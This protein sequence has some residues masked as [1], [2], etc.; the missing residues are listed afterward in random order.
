MDENQVVG[1]NLSTINLADLPPEP[2]EPLPDLKPKYKKNNPMVP[3]LLI[4]TAALGILAFFT[5]S[6]QPSIK[7]SKASAD[8]FTI[9]FNTGSQ[10]VNPGDIVDVNVLGIIT[11]PMSIS[12]ASVSASFPADKLKYTG[13]TDGQFFKNMVPA[14]VATNNLVWEQQSPGV[15]AI[16]YGAF[17]TTIKPLTFYPATQSNSISTLH[18][19]VK[20]TATGTIGITM[21]PAGIQ[22]ARSDT[23]VPQTIAGFTA[24]TVNVAEPGTSTIS[25]TVRMPVVTTV[26]TT[27]P[28]TILTPIQIISRIP[29]KT[30]VITIEP[31]STKPSPTVTLKQ[32]QTVTIKPLLTPTVGNIKSSVP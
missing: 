32:L 3:F 16:T 29:S 9:S 2:V 24:C 18:F 31:T 1:N 10:M 27:P 17:Y 6:R 23:C 11:N 30:P 14:G 7:Q 12:A 4:I 8:K 13:K 22:A 21:I 19:K 26:M 28:N 15:I 20:D 25:V 5:S